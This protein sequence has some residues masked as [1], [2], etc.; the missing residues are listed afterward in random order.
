M[1]KQKA[2]Y[3][4]LFYYFTAKSHA[5]IHSNELYTFYKTVFLQKLPSVVLAS[6]KTYKQRLLNHCGKVKI[7]Q[8]TAYG[9]GSKKAKTEKSVKEIYDLTKTSM[10]YQKVL[11]NILLTLGKDVKVLEL[12]TS[13]GVSAMLMAQAK[14]CV[15]IDSIDANAVLLDAITPHVSPKI[16]LHKAL[17]TDVV[18]KLCST[19]NYKLV[20]IDGDHRGE[21]IL[22]F[23]HYF[24]S[25]ENKPNFLVFDDINWSDDML[26]AW[27]EIVKQSPNYYTIETFRMGIVW[28]KHQPKKMH[29]KALY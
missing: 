24:S 17:F 9:A 8:N 6:I 26:S 15:C 18:P 4:N 19:N 5:L 23:Y 10:R 21:S 7:L 12:G 22:G 28:L 16:K 2:L 1:A 27:N 20:F 14:N 13:C 29:L 3:R 25:L 11:Y